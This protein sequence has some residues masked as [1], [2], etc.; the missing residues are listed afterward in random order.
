MDKAE[1]FGF[2]DAI[3]DMLR[4]PQI[5]YGVFD[6]GRCGFD[7]CFNFCWEMD[8]VPA[9]GAGV[10]ADGGAG[11]AEGA[12]N[13]FLLHAEAFKFMCK[14]PAQRGNDIV[15]FY[16]LRQEYFRRFLGALVNHS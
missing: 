8:E 16:L 10:L 4:F 6:P 13:I 11:N 2:P 15:R 5:A 12:G 3:Q 7:V 14:I 1:G 9:F